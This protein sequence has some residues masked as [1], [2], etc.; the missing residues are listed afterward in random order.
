[1][2]DVEEKSMT[3]IC[4]EISNGAARKHSRLIKVKRDQGST[5]R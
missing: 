5:V 4:V 2:K 1:M 3:V